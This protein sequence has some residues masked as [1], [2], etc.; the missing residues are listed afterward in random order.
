M[1]YYNGLEMRCLRSIDY[2]AVI[3][4][5]PSLSGCDHPDACLVL[6]TRFEDGVT[7]CLRVLAQTHSRLDCSAWR[8]ASL[9]NQPGWSFIGGVE[10]HAEAECRSPELHGPIAR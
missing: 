4:S 9:Q 8:Q 6:G 2:F 5:F 1:K 7:H 10:D 3:Q